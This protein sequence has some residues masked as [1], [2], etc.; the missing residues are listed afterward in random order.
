MPGPY[1]YCIF[2][3][4]RIIKPTKFDRHGQADRQQR[5]ADTQRDKITAG[6]GA[7]GVPG[8]FVTFSKAAQLH[9]VRNRVNTVQAR[10][11]QRQQDVDRVFQSLEKR[12]AAAQFNACLLYTSPSPRDTR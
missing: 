1:K 6:E 7:A 9:G 11:N 2:L 4:K 12:L 8:A 10:Q 5:D 3:H